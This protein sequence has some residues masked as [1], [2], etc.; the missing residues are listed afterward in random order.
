MS[1]HATHTRHVFNGRVWRMWRVC[2]LQALRGIQ[3][4]HAKYAF[5]KRG[6]CAAQQQVHHNIR[7]EVM[8]ELD[9]WPK[10]FW[11]AVVTLARQ[12]FIDEWLKQRADVTVTLH[13]DGS[14]KKWRSDDPETV[15]EDLART[16]RDLEIN[17]DISVD[18]RA[19]GVVR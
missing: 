19:H 8:S 18:L 2:E 4:T 7:G 15:F 13:D 10:R 16:L 1:T 12:T 17:A 5:Q 9:D 11:D 6:A 3:A 14:V